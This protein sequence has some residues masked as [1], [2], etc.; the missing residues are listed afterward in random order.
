M[1]EANVRGY[2]D[3]CEDRTRSVWE[4]PRLEEGGRRCPRYALTARVCG[5]IPKSPEK[6]VTHRDHSKH[7][8][9]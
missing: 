8:R 1:H 7:E 4:S 6:V 9:T 5:L 3:E 2:L